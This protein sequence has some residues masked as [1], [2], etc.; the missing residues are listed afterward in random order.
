[1]TPFLLALA[2]CLQDPVPVPPPSP[3]PAVDVVIVVNDDD[4]KAF[5]KA[6]REAVDRSDLRRLQ[7]FIIKRRLNSPRF[8]ELVKSEYVAEQYWQDPEN[9]SA[10][11][12]DWNNVDWAKLIDLILTLIKI[13]G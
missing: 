3:T 1:M 7:K 10:S 8:V 5:V 2:V 6:A 9:F 11:A 13:F 12:I 4:N